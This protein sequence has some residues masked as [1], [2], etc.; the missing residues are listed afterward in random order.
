M[1]LEIN[2]IIAT[3]KEGD[4]MKS[5]SHVVQFVFDLSKYFIIPLLVAIIISVM[6]YFLG[7]DK[8]IFWTLNG[9]ILLT[10]LGGVLYIVRWFFK[11]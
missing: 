4:N 6:L 11:H 8:L 3:P 2:I 9:G 7:M 10:L 5:L 1:D